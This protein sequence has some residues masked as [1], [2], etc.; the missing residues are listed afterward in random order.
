MYAGG[1]VGIRNPRGHEY[2]IDDDQDTCLRHLSFVTMLLK[3]VEEAG[4]E[5]KIAT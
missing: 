5:L 2:E 4:Y 1:I 3:K